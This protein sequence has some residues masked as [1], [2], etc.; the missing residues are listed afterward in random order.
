MKILKQS[1][2]VESKCDPSVIVEHI[3]NQPFVPS[4]Y[5]V[6]YIEGNGATLHDEFGTV[7]WNSYNR[8]AIAFSA[9]YGTCIDSSPDTLYAVKPKPLY[10]PR[11]VFERISS[12]KK[13]EAKILFSSTSLSECNKFIEPI[14]DKMRDC[15]NSI[16]DSVAT[17][18]LESIVEEKV[19]I[20]NELI[21]EEDF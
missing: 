18:S 4:M 14:Y 16:I 15:A 13:S 1:V 19:C 10:E 5:Y 8:F 3:T 20:K 11:F 21:G 7:F 12:I 17:S 2:T 6:I 9:K